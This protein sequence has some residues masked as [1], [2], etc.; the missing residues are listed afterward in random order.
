MVGIVVQA[1]QTALP[2]VVILCVPAITVGFLMAFIWSRLYKWF[3]P[4]D[5]QV[6]QKQIQWVA[7]SGYWGTAVAV[8]LLLI[9]HALAPSPSGANTPQTQDTSAPPTATVPCKVIA[10]EMLPGQPQHNVYGPAA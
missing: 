8:G 9:F 10:V 2:L 4:Y 3:H 6:P 5:S 7:D 1:V